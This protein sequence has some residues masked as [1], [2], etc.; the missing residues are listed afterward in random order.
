MSQAEVALLL[1]MVTALSKAG[2]SCLYVS[3]RLD[4]I[5]ELADTVTAMRDGRVIEEL[6]GDQISHRR[7]VELITAAAPTV[8]T[9]VERPARADDSS[10][11]EVTNLGG[12]LLSDITFAVRPGE[13]V[14]MAGLIASG[15]NEVLDIVSGSQR[16][17]T[18]AVTLDGR[19]L[20][21]GS[22]KAASRAGIGYLPGDRTLAVLPN[23]LVRQNVTVA[24]L[25]HYSRLG[26]PGTRRERT[27]IAGPLRRVG[28]TRSTE[29]AISTLSGGN[30]QKALLAR[31]SVERLRILLL[32]DP[33][34]G[35]DIGA[36]AEIHDALR[37]LAASGVSVLLYSSDV[38]ELIS[39]SD[40]VIILDRGSCV[41]E[42]HQPHVTAEEVLHAMTGASA[43]LPAGRR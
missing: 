22:R 13:I 17:T 42:L 5:I 30:Q 6:E 7:L 9:R 24:N 20:K 36:R 35:V 39:L 31:W 18:G 16:Q 41:A 23:H 28:Y 27:G 33:T 37:Q 14:G 25:H 11:L 1:E 26:L 12:R 29:I 8:D 15:A 3:H 4:E 34:I 21:P 10:V 2:V 40:R 32:D 38:D 43:E 19:A